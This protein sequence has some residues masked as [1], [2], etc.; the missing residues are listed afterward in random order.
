MEGRKKFIRNSLRKHRR[1]MGLSQGEVKERLKLKSTAMI[2]RW[3]KGITMP[4][5]DNL[6]QLS[7]LYKTLVNQLYYDLAQ[8]YQQELYPN[9]SRVHVPKKRRKKKNKRL[10]RGP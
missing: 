1:L 7:T 3:E 6:L 8:H 9:E 4:S 2:S 10:D 5:G